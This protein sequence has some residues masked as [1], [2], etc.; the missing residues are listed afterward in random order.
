MVAR[1]LVVS[2]CFLD[3]IRCMFVTLTQRVS[4]L[5]LVVATLFALLL[6]AFLLGFFACRCT[7]TATHTRVQV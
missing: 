4:R 2:A 6:G 3:S 1:V 7:D 5:G